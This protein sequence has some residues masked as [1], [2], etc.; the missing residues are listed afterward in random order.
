[1]TD[2][3]VEAVR[4]KLAERL[5]QMFTTEM[6]GGVFWRSL[7]L[8]DKGDRIIHNGKTWVVRYGWEWTAVAGVPVYC[9]EL[10]PEGWY[11]HRR[12]EGAE[13]G[14]HVETSPGG[15]GFI[16]TTAKKPIPGEPDASRNARRKPW[17]T[18]AN[19]RQ[20]E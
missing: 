17:L 8:H 4:A 1:M 18:D 5:P 2:I 14:T 12:I 15:I 11:A 20:D 6:D 3:D 13:A 9:A 19:N 10:D 7:E 16:R